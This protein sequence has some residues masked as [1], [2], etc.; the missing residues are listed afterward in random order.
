MCNRD[1]FFCAA[2]WKGGGPAG[3]VLPSR[4][5]WRIPLPQVA[6]QRGDLLITQ[7]FVG[8]GHVVLANPNNH[9]AGVGISCSVVIRFVA[10]S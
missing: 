2:A 3:Q 1:A 8:G 4:L 10:G 5:V 7:T 6:C 9:F